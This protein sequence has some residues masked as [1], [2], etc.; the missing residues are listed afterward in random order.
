MFG[1]KAM[2]LIDDKDEILDAI[3]SVE[4]RMV[5]LVKETYD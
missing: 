1:L 5:R 4:N 2:R 3:K